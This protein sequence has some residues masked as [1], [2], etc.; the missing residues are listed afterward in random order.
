MKARLLYE[1][2]S[3][4]LLLCTGK[5]KSLTNLEA[6]EFLMNFDNQTYYSEEGKW[7]YD[8]LTM[9]GYRGE[10][11]ATVCDSGILHIVNAKALRSIFE[12]KES[13][14]ITAKE[15][16]ELHNKKPAI[17]RRLCQN[18]RIIGAIQ[19]GKTWLIPANSAYPADER[20]KY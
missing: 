14:M 11:I 10:T 9:E 4:R 8:G 15:Y 2:D 7:D 20:I 3:I 1:K 6:F 12:N 13:N 18:G 5:I 19:K 17:I 16:A